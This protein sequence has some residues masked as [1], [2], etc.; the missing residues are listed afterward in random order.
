M[1]LL[2]LGDIVGRPG[3]IAVAE[4]LPGLRDRWRLDCVVI[5]AGMFGAAASRA[6]R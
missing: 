6:V 5:T 3:R 2:F 4:R 1:R